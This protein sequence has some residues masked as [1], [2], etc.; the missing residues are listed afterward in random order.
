MPMI[1]NPIYVKYQIAQRV[2]NKIKSRS[3]HMKTHRV[4]DNETTVQTSNNQN[5]IIQQQQQQ[6]Q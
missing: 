5:Q 2:F 1:P 6:Q 3:A 4:T